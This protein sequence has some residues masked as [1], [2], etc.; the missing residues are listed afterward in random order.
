MRTYNKILLFIFVFCITI[1]LTF[2]QEDRQV[3]HLYFT[4]QDTTDKDTIG[5]KLLISGT[6]QTCAWIDS[7]NQFYKIQFIKEELIDS[8]GNNCTSDDCAYSNWTFKIEKGEKKLRIRNRKGCPDDVLYAAGFLEWNWDYDNV[9]RVIRLIN[10]KG[11]DK[12]H[13]L[14]DTINKNRLF[15]ITFKEDD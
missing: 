14:I 10:D 11:E 13:L 4:E 12:F 9:G 3:I 1:D 7:I 5:E 8:L 2:G 15:I 6:W